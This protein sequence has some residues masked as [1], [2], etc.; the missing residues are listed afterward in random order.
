MCG[1]RGGGVWACIP[2][3]FPGW[4]ARASAQQI[5]T[6]LEHTAPAHPDVQLA[7]ARHGRRAR[8]LRLRT[9]GVSTPAE[10]PR[11]RSA[12]P[13]GAD[14]SEGTPEQA[15]LFR[16]AGV[17]AVACRA[18]AMPSSHAALATCL[19]GPESKRA[20]QL[21]KCCESCV[22]AIETLKSGRGGAVHAVPRKKKNTFWPPAASDPAK[23]EALAAQKRALYA[24]A[25][26]S[27]H[28]LAPR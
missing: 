15:T 14:A 26:P 28:P 19:R 25:D 21:V 5:D 18:R 2:R 9:R 8:H 10:R 7:V 16:D 27:C 23:L 6:I 13:N 3:A 20:I 1:G 24:T 17:G 4:R 12:P 22:C 11:A